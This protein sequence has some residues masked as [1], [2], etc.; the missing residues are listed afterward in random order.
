MSVNEHIYH[1]HQNDCCL[2]REDFG[3]DI[4]L[5]AQTITKSWVWFCVTDISIRVLAVTG[6]LESSILI[7]KTSSYL[8]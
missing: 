8:L 1:H 2:Y 4:S 6:L 3:R 7:A 5:I